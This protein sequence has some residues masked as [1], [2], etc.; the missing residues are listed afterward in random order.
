[1]SHPNGDPNEKRSEEAAKMASD[2]YSKEAKFPLSSHK[3]V[4]SRPGITFA[5]QDRL[6]KLPIPELDSSLKKYLEALR[7]LQAPKEYRDTEY[8]I[9]EFQRTEGPKL[10]E[11]LIEYAHEKAN[12]IEQFCMINT[13]FHIGHI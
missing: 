1:M 6:P 5:A 12:Y 7:P 8:A 13:T 10:Q 11:K 3:N 9:K 2:A 4:E